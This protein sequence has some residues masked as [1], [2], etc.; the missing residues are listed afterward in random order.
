MAFKRRV[1]KR[2]RRPVGSKATIKT[3]KKIVKA[4]IRRAPEIKY[5]DQTTSFSMLSSNTAFIN[6][7]AA[8]T[9]GVTNS[10]RIGDKIRLKSLHIKGWVVGDPASTNTFFNN[11]YRWFIVRGHKEGGN[12]PSINEYLES[13][14]T[15]AMLYDHRNFSKKGLLTSLC[16]VQ[17]QIPS[18]W[19]NPTVDLQ[20]MGNPLHIINKRIKLN[21]VVKFDD[22]GT[23]IM[24]GGIYLSGI[25]DVATA[26][27]SLVYNIRI[28]YTDA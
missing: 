6:L 16:D 10:G 27:P 2:K 1:F 15:T 3:V 23:S 9:Q 13:Q 11:H 22:D 26:A 20:P 12:V 28:T 25:S 4:A 19:T 5:K 8:I 7:I 17:G 14:G 18:G 21:H 24:D